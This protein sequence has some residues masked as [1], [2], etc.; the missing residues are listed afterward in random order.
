M[1]KIAVFDIDGTV[2]REAMSFIVAEELISR[3]DFPEEEQQ[4]ADA[5]HKVLTGNFCTT[6]V[7]VL[8]RGISTD[9]RSGKCCRS[10]DNLQSSPYEHQ[11]ITNS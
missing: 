7:F 2:Y 1:N 10:F 11:S 9:C 4:L 3:Y 6:I 8:D 5:R